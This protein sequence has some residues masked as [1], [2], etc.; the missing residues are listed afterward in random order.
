MQR[1]SNR[2]GELFDERGVSPVIGVILVDAGT[3]E[4]TL[5]HNGGDAIG[6]AD[7][8]I[9]IERGSDSTTYDEA[10]S[11]TLAV[12]ESTEFN[13]SSNAVGGDWNGLSWT[14]TGDAITLTSGDQVTVKIIDTD[15]QRQIF[16]TTVTA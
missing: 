8:R 12:G 3:D 14:K 9:I 16:Q 15:S 13:T 1:N 5:E 4:V 11:A 2:V 6:A 7:A 10:N